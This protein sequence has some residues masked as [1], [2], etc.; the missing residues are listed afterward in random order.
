[1]I[2]LITNKKG[3]SQKAWLQRVYQLI[4]QGI[5]ALIIREKELEVEEIKFL[6]QQIIAYKKSSNRQVQIILH[7]HAQLAWELEVDGIHLPYTIWK[8]KSPNNWRKYT[9]TLLY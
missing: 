3:L 1:M 7:T 4:D 5:D 8:T 2:Y 9:L 6:T